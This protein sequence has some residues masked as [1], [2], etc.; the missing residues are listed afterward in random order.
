MSDVA[1]VNQ[2]RRLILKRID[3]VDCFLKSLCHILIRFF[4]EAD[5]AIADLNE[6]ENALATV[7]W[8]QL[9]G[10]KHT[11]IHNPEHSGARPRHALKETAPLELIIW[12]FFLLV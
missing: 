5:V 4:V 11:S 12:I 7:P 3:F 8:H 9:A 1:R 2:E 10:R 6:A